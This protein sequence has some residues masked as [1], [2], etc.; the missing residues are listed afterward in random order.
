M[1]DIDIRTVILALCL[2]NLA[3]VLLLQAYSGRLRAGGSMRLFIAGKTAQSAAW[4][5]LGLRGS[6]PLW[7]S[8]HAG[9]GLLLAGFACEAWSVSILRWSAT[10]LQGRIYAG[11]SLLGVLLFE[12][13]SLV[14]PPHVRVAVISLVG[15]ALCSTPGLVLVRQGGASVLQRT[16][17]GLYLLFGVALA[18]RFWAGLHSDA[19]SLLSVGRIQTLNFAA[20]YL[21]MLLGSLGYLLLAKERDDLEL[22]RAA[23][24]DDLTGLLNRRA[25]MDQ[26][27]RL[28]DLAARSGRPVS[29]CLADLDHF[30][31][32]NDTWGHQVG[33]RVL[34]DFAA[35]AME[36]LRR[37][38]VLARLGG[39]E[40]VV[41]L[42]E[43][44]S[45]AAMLT[46]ERIRAGAERR[47]VIPE[48]VYT[49]SIG[50]AT[51]EKT[52]G[53]R[54]LDLMLRRVDEALYTAKGE[55][56]NRVAACVGD[57]GWSP[58]EPLAAEAD[59]AGE[60]SSV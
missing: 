57:C 31:R 35:T 41:M 32:V 6:I 54:D 1:P 16:I 26:A 12:V 28:L 17:G 11:L 58:L 15:F 29:L 59:G 39:E 20:L 38:D 14:A 60:G 21:L 50:V 7:F 52:R 10:P 33:D 45:E 23:T 4:L 56:R 2:G 44:G 53:A 43:T 5:A 25:F 51:L 47:R 42:P 36:A 3:S 46:A 27:G 49:V 8:I 55:G 24:H 22:L 37:T 18:L 34:R 30:K 13:V 40:F 19:I 9:N 48:P